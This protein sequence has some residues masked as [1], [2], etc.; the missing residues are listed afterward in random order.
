[1]QQ[2]KPALRLARLD[3]LYRALNATLEAIMRAHSADD[4]FRAVCDASV[5]GAEFLAATIFIREPEGPWLNAVSST[6]PYAHV[7]AGLRFSTDENVPEGRGMIGTAYRRREPCISNDI[8]ADERLRHWWDTARDT[9]ANAIAALPLVRADKAIGVLVYYSRM[10]DEFDAEMLGLL[11]RLST[12]VSFALDS[13][14]L[15]AQ[16]QR[17]EAATHRASRMYAALSATNEAI[18]RTR[19]LQELYQ[20]VCEAAVEGSKYS[21]AAMLVPDPEAQRLVVVAAAGAPLGV[22]QVREARILLDAD[23][24]EGQG[25]AAIA[26][27]GAK[28]FTSADYQND[29][30]T[31]PWHAAARASAAGSSAAVP[32]MR[33]ERPLGVLLFFSHEKHAFDQDIVRLLER[34]SENVSFAL[35]SFEREAERKAAQDRIQ[36]MATHDGLTGLPNRVMFAE[37]LSMALYSAR[38]Y[39]RRFAVLFI[40]LDR[41]KFINDTLGHEAG[42]TL[43]KALTARFKGALRDSDVVARLGGDEFIGLVQ[44]VNTAEQVGMV[45]RKLLAAASAP[46]SLGS[47][48][49]QVS[50][51]IGIALY[52]D[53]GGDERTLMKNAD[54][55]MY[56]AKEKGKNNFQFYSADTRS[57]SLDRLAVETALRSALENHEFH[58]H[59]QARQELSSQSITGVEALLR[60]HNPTLG[61]VPPS[62]F[63]PVAE[64]SGL[65]VAIG[66]WVLHTVCEQNKSWLSQGLPPLCIAVNL[67]ARQFF[68]GELLADVA[69]A[70]QTSDLAPGALE[71]EITEALVMQNPQRAIN[72]LTALKKLGVRLAIDDFGTGYSALGHLTQVLIDTLKIDRSF[73]NEVACNPLERS[74]AGNIVAMGKALSLT[75]VAKGVETPEQVDFLRSHACDEV[76][77]YYFSRPLSPHQFASL[78]RKNARSKLA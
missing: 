57:P 5:N 4:L 3:R 75:V 77:G 61:D 37:L 20:R 28:T 72:Q 62:L 24:P 64:Q 63:L 55:A 19:S 17:A 21:L 23:L 1:M 59:Y 13:F 12:N 18:T 60:W 39:E 40:D 54:T 7:A 49:C 14:E 47:Q 2:D 31:R 68:D 27:R 35:E 67:S 33:Q 16:R 76:Q 9:G 58:Q 30:L 52:P 36:Y 46:V 42:D 53:S 38:R 45:A 48:T 34:L 73:I 43:L 78:M 44:E 32:L 65:I 71:L 15:E 10:L 26:F 50:A 11:E 25:P 22:A 70:L 29:P 66:K 8:Q 51:S 74:V 56:L 41:F 6:G 69:H